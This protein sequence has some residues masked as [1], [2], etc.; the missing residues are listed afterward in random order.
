[1]HAEANGVVLYHRSFGYADRAS[2]RVPT[3]DTSFRVGSVTKQLTAAAV[4]TLVEA[5]RLA[6]AETVAEIL[7]GYVGPNPDAT[8]RQLLD[9][10][11]GLPSYTEIASIMAHRDQPHSPADLV[12]ATATAAARF[13]PGT[14]WAYSNT[15]YILLGQIIEARAGIPYER[16]MQAM[17][18]KAGMTRTTVGDAPGLPNRARAY[19]VVDQGVLPA[20]PIDM[21]VPWAA[22]AVRSTVTDL[23]AW[24]RALRAGRILSSTAQALWT[25]PSPHPAPYGPYACGLLVETRGAKKI[26]WHGGGIDGFTSYFA[27][28]PEDGVTIT[29]WQNGSPMAAY[30]LGR[31][32]VEALYPAADGSD[33]DKARNKR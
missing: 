24:D 11:A 23:V 27:R 25:S 18:E 33:G 16:Y 2:S 9:H 28:V 21:S 29:V 15:H 3:V 1:M 30:P 8:V 22:G 5:D 31:P 26:Y 10:T 12:A 32:L 6:L 13:A 4:L 19:R 20:H 14:A 17:F 7:P